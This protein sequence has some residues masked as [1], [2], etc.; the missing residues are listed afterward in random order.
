MAIG[1]LASVVDCG[2]AWL[3]SL[4]KGSDANPELRGL[5]AATIAA[6]QCRLLRAAWVEEFNFCMLNRVKLTL[7]ICHILGIGAPL[8][9]RP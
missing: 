6:E 8:P 7:A 5:L 4:F 3:A 9:A 1:H 2:P